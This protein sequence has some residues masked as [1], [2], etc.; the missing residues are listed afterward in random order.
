MA[1]S[2]QPVQ[3]FFSLPD[4]DVD[5]EQASFVRPKPPWWRRRGILIA[6]ALLLALLVA[7][8]VFAA[9]QTHQKSVTYQYQQ[10]TQ[11]DFSLLVNA[12][13]PVQSGTYNV[14]FTGTGK[15]T[16]IDVKVGQTVKQG[17][18]LAKLDKTSL[19]DAVNEAQASLLAA[20]S[21][22]NNAQSQEPC[23][24]QRDGL[25]SGLVISTYKLT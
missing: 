2:P 6:S 5:N 22:L 11:G 9:V 20:S 18:V 15:I 17:Q 23:P 10:V 1:Q 21:S 14:E 8:S 24:V 3:P 16:E 4:F 7:G 19:Q 12:T 25:A 13:G